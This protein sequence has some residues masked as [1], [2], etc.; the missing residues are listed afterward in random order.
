MKDK[1]GQ[2]AISIVFVIGII[3]LVMILSLGIVFLSGIINWTADIIVPEIGAINTTEIGL[4]WTPVHNA[5]FGTM[6]KVIQS[7][8][9]VSG[10]LLMMGIIMCLGVSFAFRI[11]GNKWLGIVF[12][13]FMVLLV[14]ASMFIGNIY[15]GFYNDPNTEFTGILHEHTMGSWILLRSPIIFT[16][17]GFVCGIIIFT[18]GGKEVL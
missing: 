5:T 13:S 15:E 18:G 12:I 10:V 3:F 9:W 7:G 11:S 8:T 2:A 4:N 6:D 16:I 17:L 14:I 1:E